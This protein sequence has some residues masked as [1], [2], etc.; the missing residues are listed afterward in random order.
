LVFDGP[1]PVTIFL[2]KIIEKTTFLGP[3]EGIETIVNI[4]V[5]A[6]SPNGGKSTENGV[7]GAH[8]L[9]SF[10]YQV[11]AEPQ[12]MGLNLRFRNAREKH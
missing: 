8:F 10:W 4:G 1:D 6:Q 7:P 2:K 9:R 3:V 5:D 11:G 12:K